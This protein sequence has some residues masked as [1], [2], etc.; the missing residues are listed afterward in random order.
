MHDVRCDVGYEDHDEGKEV[1]SLVRANSEEWSRDMVVVDIR[2]Y[3]DF[4]A[5]RDARSLSNRSRVA[6]ELEKGV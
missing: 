2:R 3:L 1:S 5:R 4:V 6:S